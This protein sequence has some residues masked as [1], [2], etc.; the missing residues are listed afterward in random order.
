MK[1]YLYDVDDVK[2]GKQSTDNEFIEEYSF[3]RKR[4]H[5]SRDGRQLGSS[6][7]LTT[8]NI[9][10]SG[11]HIEVKRIITKR[12]YNA[13]YKNRDV[14]RHVVKQKRISFIWDMQSF[15]VHIYREPMD[16]EHLCLVHVQQH[17]SSEKKDAN[18]GEDASEEVHV[19]MPKFLNVERKLVEGKED[20]QKY[21]AFSISLK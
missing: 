2:N 4:T 15:N 14:N 11:K 7:G 20:N 10:K 5:L 18:D 13:A 8:V 17:Q 1:V 9:T 21:G 19:H 12:E 6:Y 3:I 16:V